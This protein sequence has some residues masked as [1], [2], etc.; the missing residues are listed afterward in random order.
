MW[1]EGADLDDEGDKSLGTDGLRPPV[2]RVSYGFTD[3][4]IGP[5]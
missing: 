3:Q 2:Q 5:L 1:M 4:A